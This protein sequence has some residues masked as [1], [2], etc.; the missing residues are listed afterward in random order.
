MRGYIFFK[1]GKNEQ[2]LEIFNQ[3]INKDPDSFWALS[4]TTRKAIIQGDTLT[5]RQSVQKREQL[6]IT[7]P[8]PIYY[9]A[10]DFALLDDKKGCLK[11]LQQAVDGGYFNYPAM[12]RQSDL[13]IGRASCRERV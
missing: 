6:N 12:L 4:S 13:E 8:E 11:A 7:D 1:Q 9:L 10:S 3:I 5:A 2:A